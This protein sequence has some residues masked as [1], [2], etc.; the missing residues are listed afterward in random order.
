MSAAGQNPISLFVKAKLNSK[1]APNLNIVHECFI[2][3]L[4]QEFDLD[5]TDHIILKN[6]LIDFDPSRNF[7]TL[8]GQIICVST[9]NNNKHIVD[10]VYA[11]RDFQPLYIA[12]SDEFDMVIIENGCDIFICE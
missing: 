10:K 2:P 9:N 7:L 12:Q 3:E 8:K 6:A 1:I 4:E 5:K 11:S